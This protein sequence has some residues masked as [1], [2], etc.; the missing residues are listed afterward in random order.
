MNKIFDKIKSFYFRCKNWLK[1][2]KEKFL[3]YL[4]RLIPLVLVSVIVLGNSCN[5]TSA[6]SAKAEELNTG[7]TYS[8]VAFST[9]SVK[10]S[11]DVFK[12]YIQPNAINSQQ[13]LLESFYFTLTLRY[14]VP[15]P[16]ATLSLAGYGVTIPIDVEGNELTIVDRY[17][18]SVS[19]NDY[20]TS[21]LVGY[22]GFS[23]SSLSSYRIYSYS[24]RYVPFSSSSYGST[25]FGTLGYKSSIP[26]NKNLYIYQWRLTFDGSSN[27]RFVLT[28]DVPIYLNETLP[29][30]STQWL[31]SFPSS[32]VSNDGYSQGYD[33]GF[34]AGGN[35]K[36]DDGYSKGY[37]DGETVGYSKGLN[38]GLNTTLADVTPMQTISANV[39]SVLKLELFPGF[40]IY[41]I[42]L[43]SIT[44]FLICVVIKSLASL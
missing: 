43:I 20:T 7:S 31:N 35:A 22:S 14:N 2:N 17:S 13:Y 28:I 18:P 1:D 11:D 42:I 25:L 40:K 39:S 10:G 30:N 36:Y 26:A 37:D 3:L 4:L 9:N 41:T 5:R 16:K 27:G 6:K 38:E 19:L 34:L 44:C 12:K 15:T 33:D 21:Y 8:T 24:Y 32:N 23:A 29:Y